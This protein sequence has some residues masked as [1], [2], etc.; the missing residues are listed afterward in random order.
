MLRIPAFG[1]RVTKTLLECDCADYNKTESN[2]IKFVVVVSAAAAGG[3][4]YVWLI[5]SLQSTI[6]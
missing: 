6:L 5:F 4:V 3:C 1:Q 2:K